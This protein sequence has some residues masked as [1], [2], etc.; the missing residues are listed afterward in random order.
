MKTN[1]RILFFSAVILSSFLLGAFF[2]PELQ[3]IISRDQVTDAAYIMGLEM[4]E[5]EIDS[6]LPDLES[7][8]TDYKSNREISIANEVVPSLLF[9]PF[10]PGFEME[11]VQNL[12][13]FS[14]PGGVK[15]PEKLE[16]LAFYTVHQLAELIR[17]RQITSVEL[18][19]FFIERLKKYD[20]T[21]H[22]VITLTE[23]LALEQ[24]ARADAEIAQG[25]Y[26]G[27]LHGIPY[28]AKDL[29]ATKQYKT[30]WG[31]MPFKEQE[32][33]YDAAV[34][35]RLE[36]AGAVLTA[37]LT[38]GALAWG[39]VWYGEKTR[40]P[41]DTSRGSSGS[42]AGSA[43]AVTAGLLP[44]AIG[45]ETLGSIVS[46]STVCGATGLR[47]TFGRVSRYGAMALSWSMDKIGPI[48]RSVED[49]A[50]VFNAIY[51]KD[52]RDPFTF[53][54][55]FNYK[56]EFDAKS[57]RIG[58]LQSAFA[59]QYPFKRQDSLALESL[60][61]LGYELIPIELPPMPELGIILSAEAAAAFDELTR[62]GNDDQMVRQIRRAWPNVF[63]AA[64]F[65][66]AVE[67][68]Q[69]NRLRTQ[70]IAQMDQVFQQVDV[71]VHPSWASSSLGITNYTGHPCVVLPNGFRDGRP[72]S[73]SFT[74]KLF[75]E[76]ELLRLAKDFQ[77]ATN[78]HK[79]H[80]ELD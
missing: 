12:V 28:G 53:D 66:P 42:S 72:T 32:F 54:A 70:L 2:S 34:I 21:L 50:I 56:H 10:P 8:R 77:D 63:R 1:R 3:E 65:I 30:T 37:K 58:Y 76:A 33:D 44:F 23:E 67:Y 40:N 69:A 18:S 51:G 31:A 39:D 73:I 17:T 6:L 55:P 38:L 75:G 80:P 20:P 26:R 49:C 46:P 78:F 24:A 52:E 29:L 43:S 5:A 14:N 9:N 15:L 11:K 16:D 7:A 64:R 60:K 79:Q 47:P 36:E 71:Y 59:G 62:N 13:S 27:L 45:T 35:E 74:G 48:C 25:K 68:I 19:R 61:N 41:W 22:C 57:L 4:T